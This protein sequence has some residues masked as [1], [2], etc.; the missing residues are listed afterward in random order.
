MKRHADTTMPSET[1]NEATGP[2]L[3]VRMADTRAVAGFTLIEL[4]IAIVIVAIL[5]TVAFPAYQD[6]VRSGRRADAR[7]ALMQLQ[8]AQERYR[9][10]HT[11][12]A[13]SIAKLSLKAGSEGDHYTLSVVSADSNS[14]I[15][16]A[17]PKGAQ[18]ADDCGAFAINQNGP[19]TSGS[20]AGA[21]CWN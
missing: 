14:F 15:V 16:L 6:S 2:L 11:A 8:I 9:G 20:Y 10:S 21:D 18:A 1:T 7:N 5:A 4:M 19:M 12:Y 3:Q 17:E 13:D